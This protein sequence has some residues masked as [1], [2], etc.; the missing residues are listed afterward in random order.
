MGIAKRGLLDNERVLDIAIRVV[1]AMI[2]LT[3]AIYLGVRYYHDN[4]ELQRELPAYKAMKDLEDAV[5][6]NPLDLAARTKLASAY[7]SLRMWDKAIEQCNEVLKVDKENQACLTMAGF[8]YMQKGDYTSALKYYEKE[9]D[10]YSYAGYALENK[11][12]EDAYFNAGVIYWK[13]KNLDKAISYVN[14]AALIRRTDA[15][16]W[17][18]LG[19]LYYEKKLYNNAEQAFQKALRFVPNYPDALLGLGKVYEKTDM[20]G[21][22]VNFYERAY[23]ADPKLKEAKERSDALMEKL[24]QKSNKIDINNAKPEDADTLIQLGYAYMGRREFAKAYE[25]FD[26]A[27][28]INPK[29][30]VAYYAYGYAYERQWAAEKEKLDQTTTTPTLEALKKKAEEKYKKCLALDPEYEGAMAGLKRLSL[31]ITEEEVIQR[32]VIVRQKK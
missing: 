7:I 15:D 10:A 4:V 1:A 23:R 24:V 21:L 9:I 17:F 12:L 11:W 19:R 26:R 5:R 29:S 14:S 20:W 28:L 6:K 31:G 25:A 30:A 2:I 13:K 3:L 32:D 18:F 27:I 22:A 16:V 8:A